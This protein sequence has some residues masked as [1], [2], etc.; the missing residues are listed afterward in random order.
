MSDKRAA[1]GT[2]GSVVSRE[3]HVQRIREFEQA[4]AALSDTDPSAAEIRNILANKIETEKKRI[5]ECKPLGQQLGDAQSALA[6]ARKRREA[7]LDQAAQAQQSFQEAEQDISDI[8]VGITKLEQQ[9]ASSSAP[10]APLGLETASQSL[11]QAFA[12]A[13]ALG[14]DIGDIE[15]AR[16][17]LQSAYQV[18]SKIE[19]AKKARQA[20]AAAQA[21]TANTSPPQSGGVPQVDQDE[22]LVFDM[23]ADPPVD[24]EGEDSR[25]RWAEGSPSGDEELRASMQAAF[26]PAAAPQMPHQACFSRGISSLLQEDEGRRLSGDD[27]SRSESMHPVLFNSRRLPGQL[28]LRVATANVNTLSPSESRGGPFSESLLGSA[29]AA[30]L[31]R[32]FS[33]HC[34]DIVGVQEG[35]TQV[36]Q[37]KSGSEYRMFISG[38]TPQGWYGS[39]V[40]VRHELNARALSS[41]APHPRIMSVHLRIGEHTLWVVSAHAPSAHKGNKEIE[42]FWRVMDSI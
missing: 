1:I 12:D 2:P 25:K 14:L 18:I 21:A 24:G 17:S 37:V 39:Q 15:I 7:A 32:A 22:D 16:Q 9:I 29:R 13:T 27:L 30:F 10:G 11:Q 35:R 8:S 33:E 40:W 34:L 28:A 3:V 4:M 19:A 36:S 38:A 5:I 26:Q 31:E 41:S 20:P 42:N 23:F 6:R